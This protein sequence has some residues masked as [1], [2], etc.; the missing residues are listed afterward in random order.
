MENN[1]IL[2]TS[3]EV[4]DKETENIEEKKTNNT[5]NEKGGVFSRSEYSK[6]DFWNE[7]FQKSLKNKF[8]LKKL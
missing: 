1:N 4:V 3:P 5:E 2:N 7:R 8:F 6:K